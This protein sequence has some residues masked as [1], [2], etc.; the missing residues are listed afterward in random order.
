VAAG[1]RKYCNDVRN[2]TDRTVRR[3]RPVCCSAFSSIAQ[4]MQQQQQAGAASLQ[5]FHSD[6]QALHH[7]R[8]LVELMASYGVTCR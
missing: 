4:Q 1:G 6:K 7:L 2:R 8:E 5:P 3:R